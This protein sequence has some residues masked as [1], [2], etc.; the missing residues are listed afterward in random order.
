MI[1]IDCCDG[2]TQAELG[3]S[4]VPMGSQEANGRANLALEKAVADAAAAPSPASPSHAEPSNPSPSH[5]HQD[6]Q[7]P[8]ARSSDG[9]N[10]GPPNAA[11]PLSDT[12]QPEATADAVTSMPPLPAGASMLNETLVAGPACLSTTTDLPDP[13]QDGTAALKSKP[14]ADSQLH[15]QSEGT[16]QEPGKEGTAAPLSLALQASDL[17]CQDDDHHDR[18]DDHQLKAIDPAES[19]QKVERPKRKLP[20]ASSSP[21]LSL[22]GAVV[23]DDEDVPIS[24]IDS[25]DTHSMHGGSD[26]DDDINNNILAAA[27]K[28]PN[29]KARTK[30]LSALSGKPHKAGGRRAQELALNQDS[31]YSTIMALLKDS[32][33]DRRAAAAAGSALEAGPAGPVQIEADRPPGKDLEASAAY[34]AI[35]DLLQEDAGPA[36]VRI[37]S[38]SYLTTRKMSDT[39]LMVEN[40]MQL[41]VSG[42]ALNV[43]C[44]A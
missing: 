29:G 17:L 13:H 23:E 28:G 43:N 36:E 39:H 6:K 27:Q 5:L 44:R 7:Q 26:P 3:I 19:S 4:A 24:D 12:P 34:N 38:T 30:S 31:A 37:L 2:D 11:A 10:G 35:S 14:A 20:E 16:T 41:W 8:P 32:S 22:Q 1:A 21:Y 18:A 25:E 9:A 42:V 33:D 40:G 15:A